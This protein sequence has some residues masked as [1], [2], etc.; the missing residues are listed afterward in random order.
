MGT[1]VRI[2]R[3]EEAAMKVTFDRWVAI[4]LVGCLAIGTVI[5]PAD[6][7]RAFASWLAV[8]AHSPIYAWS[9][10][11]GARRH[12]DDVLLR[13]FVAAR[14][15]QSARRE[16]G[17]TPGRIGEPDVRFAA[18]VPQATRTAF[19]HALDD[20]RTE[21]GDLHGKGKV[22]VMVAVDSAMRV[23]GEIVSHGITGGNG[24][25]SRVIAPSEQTGDRCVVVI[26]LATADAWSKMVAGRPAGPVHPLLDACG[27]YDAYG[28]PGPAIARYLIDSHF[29]SARGYL[30]AA[31]DHRVQQ[32]ANAW[33]QPWSFDLVAARCLSG[34]DS[35]CVSILRVRNRPDLDWQTSAFPAGTDERVLQPNPIGLTPLNRLA[36]ELG[37]ERFSRIWKSSKPLADAYLDETG[38]TWVQHSRQEYREE[39]GP[40]KAGPWTTPVSLALTLL[41]VVALVAAALRFG[42][43]PSVS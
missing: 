5:L 13:E 42:G 30:T 11:L 16:F 3:A 15:L 38:E 6:G 28:A 21:R 19:T 37:P 26:T 8:E 33:S 1:A 41:T 18:N 12:H 39:D 27:F 40:Y 24:T 22:G 4:A 31:H 43:R 23:K 2:C 9:V 34:V 17:S 35:S 25:L 10:R 7:S 32:P 29:S 14:D 36:I 20:E